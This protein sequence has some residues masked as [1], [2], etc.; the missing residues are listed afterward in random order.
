MATEPVMCQREGSGHLLDEWLEKPLALVELDNTGGHSSPL[1]DQDVPGADPR[2]DVGSPPEHEAAHD[3]VNVSITKM[4]DTPWAKSEDDPSGVTGCQD[5]PLESEPAKEYQDKELKELLSLAEAPFPPPPPP[6]HFLCGSDEDCAEYPRSTLPAILVGH[7]QV[8][9]LPSGQAE[10]GPEGHNQEAAQQV[11]SQGFSPL[12]V[13]AMEPANQNADGSQG[14]GCVVAV[15]EGQR[16]AGEQRDREACQVEEK[17]EQKE[18]G[19]GS[20]SES[21]R[22]TRSSEM[23][24]CSEIEESRN[25]V[26]EK[27]SSLSMP[28]LSGGSRMDIDPYDDG[29]SDSGVSADFST[30]STFESPN[31]KANMDFVKPSAN[32][33]PIER[34]IRRAVQREQS[35]RRSRG[36]KNVSPTT[37]YVE[38][39]LKKS[40]L[41]SGLPVKSEKSQGKDRQFAG[42]KM[43]KEIHAEVQREQ[44]LV[45]LG[46]VPGVYDKG[47]VRQL[48]ERKKLFEAFQEPRDSSDNLT[49]R[50]RVP[51]WASAND[52]YHRENQENASTPASPPGG[53]SV[54][55]G[56]SAHWLN[57]KQQQ[58]QQQ[59]Q[60]EQQEH[61]S[62]SPAWAEPGGSTSSTS[63]R[64][65][66][67]SQ[68]N[69]R[70]TQVV[71]VIDSGTPN[72]LPS[73]GGGDYLG[74]TE[75]EVEE[76]D[77]E[78]EPVPKDNP[79]FKLRSSLS[80]DKVEQDI[81]E[82]QEREKELRRL[83]T[84]LYGATGAGREERT[85]GGR[86][87]VSQTHRVTGPPAARQSLGRLGMWPPS[88]AE[89]QQVNQLESPR[90]LR[91]KTPLLQ[92]W[93]TG[94]VI[95]GHQDQD[96]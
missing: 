43:Q 63:P 76:E 49:P 12:S 10:G 6:P 24:R 29:Q 86:G 73:L 45:K 46:T 58:Q 72:A 8:E 56:Q 33:T 5:T 95:N 9:Q 54:G 74:R 38:I 84:S 66:G 4:V 53:L 71:D 78:E 27:C 94:C 37:E 41:N 69:G 88:Q 40:V 64:G 35:L 62:T 31:V 57:Q 87:P 3:N 23:V 26:I 1:Q 93:E 17:A 32:E 47:T 14:F 77:T 21:E 36:I 39:P 91:Q 13:V 85:R 15:S 52:L 48:K 82:A 79:F 7:Q 19:L 30:I 81:R 83:R 92:H 42:N 61:S 75:R 2:E 16:R 51:S 70:Q 18:G 50:T 34:E 22:L 28:K 20:D 60:Q 80:V 96:H 67:L 65:P 11:H 25:R 90:S 55:K 44:A 68:G 59:E 89:E